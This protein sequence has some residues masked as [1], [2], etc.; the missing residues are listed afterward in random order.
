MLRVGF[1]VPSLDPFPRAWW[2]PHVR[3]CGVIQIIMIFVVG[4]I[5]ISIISQFVVDVA[6]LSFLGWSHE[7]S[8]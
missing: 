2:V 3:S 5:A 1:H 6:D 4:I 7:S 8:D